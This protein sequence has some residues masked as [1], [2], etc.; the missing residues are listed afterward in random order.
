MVLAVGSIAT[1]TAT[2]A[3]AWS[4]AAKAPINGTRRV[5]HPLSFRF[6]GPSASETD[7]APNP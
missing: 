6:A 3:P 2:P 4:D 1:A 7:D 5:W